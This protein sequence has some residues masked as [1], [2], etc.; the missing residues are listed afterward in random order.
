[1]IT[2]QSLQD[3]LLNLISKSNQHTG[4]SDTDL[5]E[6]INSL[7]AMKG[8]SEEVTGELVFAGN[9]NVSLLFNDSLIPI[10]GADGNITISLGGG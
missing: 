10:T 4:K 7:I 9:G 3:K 5:T 8:T 2:M 1:M 6:A